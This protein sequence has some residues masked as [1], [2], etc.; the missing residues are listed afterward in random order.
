VSEETSVTKV[1]SQDN[2]LMCQNNGD[3][4]CGSLHRSLSLEEMTG[5][6]CIENGGDDRFE[7]IFTAYEVSVIEATVN[8]QKTK[9]DVTREVLE[10]GDQHS[11]L[12]VLS[13]GR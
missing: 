1:L 4:Y 5:K 3:C 9:L 7:A 11:F 10:K 2:C 8:K 13:E 12:Q 6:P